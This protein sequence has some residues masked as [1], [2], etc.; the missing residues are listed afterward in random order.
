M[1]AII[2]FIFVLCS[3]LQLS[4]IRQIYSLG[5]SSLIFSAYLLFSGYACAALGFD[6]SQVL[7]TKSSELSERSNKFYASNTSNSFFGH[8]WDEFKHYYISEQGRVI[9]AHN[10]KHPGCTTSEGQSYALFFALVSNDRVAFETILQWTINNLAQGD[11]TKNLPAWL[12]GVDANG[13]WL[14]LD[15]NSASDA[16]LW[17][18]YELLEAGRLWAN[19]KYT[20]L[21]MSLLK[22]IKQKEVVNIP[23]FGLMVLPGQAGFAHPPLWK[24][25][26]SYLPLQLL[27]RFALFDPDWAEI[28][29]NSIRLLLETSPLGYSPD[30]VHWEDGNGWDFNPQQEAISS[31]DAI[32]VYLWI[33][34]LADDEPNRGV[35]QEHFQ[36]I[37]NDTLRLTVPPEQINI[38]DGSLL[39]RGP[40][41]FSA[42]LLPSIRLPAALC[43]Q[44]LRI[45]AFSFDSLEYYNAVLILFGTGWFYNFYHFNRSGELIVPL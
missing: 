21:G 34:M 16:D 5:R 44:L 27:S 31:Y 15:K 26:P 11:L 29:N 23:G 2:C 43:I 32:R 7:A 35:L 38:V 4:W 3:A 25:N 41:G 13:R 19:K 10:L 45:D 30:W 39:G 8:A 22:E 6:H 40:V 14:I 9:D 36:P 33:G 24:L 42:A 1:T 20:L 18:A 37:I 28:K 17:I 12:W